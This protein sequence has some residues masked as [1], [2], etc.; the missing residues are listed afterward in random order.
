MPTGSP[1]RQTFYTKIRSLRSIYCFYRATRMQNMP[2]QNVC[3]SVGLSHAGILSKRLYIYPQSFFSPSGSPTI[4]VFPCGTGWQYSDGDPA[5]SGGVECK[6]YETNHNFRPIPRF[7]SE[8]MQNIAIV[9]ME[10]G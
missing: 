7:I 8:M 1:P 9:T 2:W 10:G 5:A 3:L 6:G 4:L